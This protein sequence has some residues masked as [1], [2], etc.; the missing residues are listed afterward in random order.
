MW[1]A[2]TPEGLTVWAAFAALGIGWIIIDA[3][4]TMEEDW[5]AN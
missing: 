5:N 3:I 4:K 1:S 2:C